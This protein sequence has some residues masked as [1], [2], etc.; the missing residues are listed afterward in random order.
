MISFDN[1]GVWSKILL[2]F[3]LIIAGNYIGNTFSCRIQHM[4]NYNIYIRHFIAIITLYFFVLIVDSKLKKYSPFMMVLV[5]IVVYIYF[6]FAVKSQ[7]K[8]FMCSILILIIVSF[9]QN[10]KEYLITKEYKTNL[11]LMYIKYI[12]KIQF[13]LI[14][15]MVLITIVGFIIYLG[16]KETEYGEKFN[17]SKFVLGT[18]TCKH[19]HDYNDNHLDFK[20]FVKGTGI[21]EK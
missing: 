21:F 8:Y 9:L 17:I 1:L 15:I 4:L 19:N 10:N 16:E 12:D 6:L 7:K 11:D 14:I 13:I 18:N 2:F 20:Y 5:S 3:Y